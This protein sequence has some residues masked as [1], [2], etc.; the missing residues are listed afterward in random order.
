[1]MIG[2]SGHDHMF[3]EG[4]SWNHMVQGGSVEVAANPIFGPA[5]FTLAASGFVSDVV[6]GNDYMEGGSGDDVLY[7]DWEEINIVRTD[8]TT[9]SDTPLGTEI[10]SADSAGIIFGNDIII[11]GEGDDFIVGDVENVDYL[12]TE[13]D[14]TLIG[15][16]FVNGIYSGPGVV[17]GNDTLTGG[18][19]DDTFFF[20]IQ[21]NGGDMQ[22]QGDD[23][24]TDLEAWTPSSLQM[25]STSMGAVWT[26]QTWMIKPPS[27]MMAQMSGSTLPAAVAS[28]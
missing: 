25:C 7:G 24:I 2:G 12:H 14:G 20:E 27:P 15:D 16:S 4:L 3:G 10:V 17:W 28:P 13:D 1:M 18:W 21:D 19:G 22:M 5:A 9:S 11:G 8:G 6:F 26:S 23:I